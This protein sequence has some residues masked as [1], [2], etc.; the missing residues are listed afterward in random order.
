MM[1]L[2][3]AARWPLW[4]I[5]TSFQWLALVQTDW[6]RQLLHQVNHTAHWMSK[7][8]GPQL[9]DRLDRADVRGLLARCCKE[10]AQLPAEAL[11][12]ELRKAVMAAEVVSGFSS[13]VNGSFFS[14]SLSEAEQV[15]H[16]ENL[17]E[18][19]VRNDVVNNYTHGFDWLETSFFGFK[20][21]KEPAHPNSML[22]A[23]ERSAYFLLNSLRSDAGSPLYGDVSVVLKPSFAHATSILSPLDSGSWAGWC[24]GSYSPPKPSYAHNCSA[25][26]GHQGLG[27]FQALDH[28][29]G[30]NEAYWS[31][32][33]AFL[34][35]LARLLA[36]EDAS[37]S[38]VGEDFVRYFEVL[39]TAEVT[40][41]DVKFVIADFPSLFGTARGVAVRSWCQKNGWLLLWSLGL[42]VGFS[43]N[44]G[45]P[46]FWDVFN[47]PGPFR[48][49]SRLIDPE[50]LGPLQP[51][52]N[53]SSDLDA[54]NASWQLLQ[55]KRGTALPLKPKDFQFAWTALE[56]QLSP[57]LWITPVRASC[58]DLDL[59]VGVTR[60]GCLCGAGGPHWSP[61][62]VMI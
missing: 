46:H 45:R 40:F 58:P 30:I 17:W 23:R 48:G 2:R 57:D 35:P 10:V 50:F 14:F 54:F 41:S 33:A 37:T 12:L 7:E 42:N 32:P 19:W 38:M 31:S 52:Q 3:F 16:Y 20:P 4:S 43:T 47:Q 56:G 55:A 18:V 27:T 49:R 9:L 44:Q 13:E 6:Q 39:P 60:K 28:L 24:H 53:V 34:R 51:W 21:F 61:E 36:G 5:F 15:D 62:S 26:P 59:C 11:V 29:F 8:F 25:F 22:E 1:T